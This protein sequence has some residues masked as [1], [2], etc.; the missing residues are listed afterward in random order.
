MLNSVPILSRRKK[1]ARAPH[2]QAQKAQALRGIRAKLYNKER[3]KEK[4]QMKKLI[5]A[6]QEKMIDVKVDKPEEGALPAYLLDRENVNRSKVHILSKTTISCD[7]VAALLILDSEQ[8][9]Q[10]KEKGKGWQVVS[11]C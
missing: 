7:L 4:I 9:S 8:H 1:E 6:H 3:F 5:N 10:T 11:T 2:E